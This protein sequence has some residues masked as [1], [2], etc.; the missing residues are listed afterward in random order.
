MKIK[1]QVFLTDV[2]VLNE[3]DALKNTIKASFGR[4]KIYMGEP[5]LAE[6]KRLH[7]AIKTELQNIS[8]KYDC[9]VSEEDHCKNIERLADAIS[10]QFSGILKDGKFKIG[11][12]QK[13]LNLYL[14]FRW[15]LGKQKL[16]PPHCPL[17]GGILKKAGVYEPWT[18]LDCIDTY[19]KW[20]KKIEAKAKPQSLSE[21]ELDTWKRRSKH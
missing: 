4:N 10:K 1:Q 17:D 18:K 3:C 7:D 15:C 16:P 8:A 6:R 12:A 20:I 5:A 19:K 9:V 2:K 14:K 11:A 21:W 13:A